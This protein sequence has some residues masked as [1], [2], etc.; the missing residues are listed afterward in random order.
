MGLIERL[1]NQ[2]G[3]LKADT[4]EEG[5]AMS[6]DKEIDDEGLNDLLELQEKVNKHNR[7]TDE[8][9]TSQLEDQ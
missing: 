2:E 6:N 9:M 8:L 3:P 5:Y 4:C 1:T 7:Q